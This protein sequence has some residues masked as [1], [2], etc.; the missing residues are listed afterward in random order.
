MSSYVGNTPRCLRRSSI[1]SR[2]RGRAWSLSFCLCADGEHHTDLNHGYEAL[3]V[4][5]LLLEG[6]EPMLLVALPDI[7]GVLPIPLAPEMLMTPPMTSSVSV[8]DTTA[9]T[10]A[11]AERITG[12]FFMRISFLLDCSVLQVCRLLITEGV[13]R[14]ELAGPLCRDDT[15]DDADGGAYPHC[16]Q[17]RR[18]GDD[19][20]DAG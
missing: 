5:V 4:F 15:E 6:G 9:R 18:C 14:V 7:E 13:D 2:G 3:F 12:S 1:H 17:D 11:M 19:R 10:S 8:K 20:V 16:K